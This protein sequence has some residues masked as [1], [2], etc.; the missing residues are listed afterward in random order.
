MPKSRL[1]CV[2]LGRIAA[3]PGTLM[4]PMYREAFLG[5][6]SSVMSS[7]GDPLTL[8]RS[9]RSLVSSSDVDE[10]PSNTLT[11]SLVMTPGEPR[12]S[13][14]FPWINSTAAKMKNVQLDEEMGYEVLPTA[15]QKKTFLTSDMWPL[16]FKHEKRM[17]NCLLCKARKL[18]LTWY[19]SFGSNTVNIHATV[20]ESS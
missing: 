12:K 17:R 3:F 16:R 11:G 1:E 8:S 9:K 2:N 18:H 20:V 4:T 10:P 19:K 13:E 7:K 5:E 6:M 15:N 14:K